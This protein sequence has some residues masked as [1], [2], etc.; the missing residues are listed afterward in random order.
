MAKRCM[1]TGKGPRIAH[2]VS[3]SHRRTKKR[4]LPNLQVKR[5][6]LPSERRF[7]R[8]TVS[9]KGMRIID[10]RGVERVVAEIRRRGIRV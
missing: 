3:H 6:W 8:L 1:V 5:Y 7:V 2:R 10:R 9:A 4:V